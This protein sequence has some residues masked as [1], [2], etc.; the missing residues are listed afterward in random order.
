M[1]LPRRLRRPIPDIDALFPPGSAAYPGHPSYPS[2]HATQAHALAWV[3]GDLVPASAQALTD[4]S[5]RVA[6]NREIAGLHYPSD[7][8]AGRLLAEHLLTLL[9]ASKA[10]QALLKAAKTE[11]P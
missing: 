2:G 10:F 4:M 11:W 7:S 1:G 3:L 9:K 6:E 8:A 5:Q